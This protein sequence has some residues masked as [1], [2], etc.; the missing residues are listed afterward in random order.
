[1]YILL[2]FFRG[3]KSSFDIHKFEIRL[4]A[5]KKIFRICQD[6][7]VRVLSEQNKQMLSMLETEAILFLGSFKVGP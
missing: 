4:S 7:H 1:M 6:E 5:L 2:V 3:K